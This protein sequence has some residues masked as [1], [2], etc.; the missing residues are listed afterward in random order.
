MGRGLY[1]AL[2]VRA[3]GEPVFG[4]DRTLVLDDVELEKHGQIRSPGWWVESHDLREGS[5]RLG[6]GK[7][8]PEIRI[9]AGPVTPHRE[10]RLGFG[11][12]RCASA[13][14]WG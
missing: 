14:A 12:G 5:T 13:S 1:G 7:Y 8:E 11:L 3:P 10:V 9:A 6:N 4:A 2:V